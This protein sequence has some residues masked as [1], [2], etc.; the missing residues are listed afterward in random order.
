MA[1]FFVGLLVPLFFQTFFYAIG[2][3]V[4]GTLLKRRD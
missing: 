2:A 3:Y 4:V 1:E